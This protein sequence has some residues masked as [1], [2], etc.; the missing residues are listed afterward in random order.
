MKEQLRYLLDS[1]LLSLTEGLM[2]SNI[3]CQ[4]QAI[5]ASAVFYRAAAEVADQL[6]T[7]CLKNLAWIPKSLKCTL[8]SPEV[9]THFNDWISVLTPLHLGLERVYFDDPHLEL[10]TLGKKVVDEKDEKRQGQ[11]LAI[12]E[13][14][15]NALKHLFISPKTQYIKSKPHES[16]LLVFPGLKKQKKEYLQMNGMAEQDLFEKAIKEG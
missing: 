1:A 10:E 2:S 12:Q 8:L 7:L 13:K 6:Q 5:I 4:K 16:C 3:D 11:V 9:D 14:A 15:I